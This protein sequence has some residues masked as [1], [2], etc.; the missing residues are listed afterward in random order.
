MTAAPA[1]SGAAGTG[2]SRRAAPVLTVLLIAAALGGWLG[3]RALAAQHHLQQARTQLTTAKAALLDRRTDDARAAIAAATRDTGRARALTGDPLWR[4]AAAVPVA[5][6]SL[7]AVRGV[8]RAFDEVA[9]TVLPP[10][11]GAAQALSGGELR[12]PGGT[13]DLE[14]L[15][16]AEPQLANSADRLSR[17]RTRLAGLPTAGVVAPVRE[18]RTQLTG[19]LDSLADVLGRS[20]Q[21][22]TLAPQLLG[23]GRPRRF[24]V[25]VQQPGE[26]RGTGGLPGGYAVLEADNGTVRVSAQGSN[27]D[28]HNGDI[29]LPEGVSGDFEQEYGANLALR[30]WQNV[31]LS[32]DLPTVAKVVAARWKAQSGQDVDGVITLDPV[33]IS[34]LLR[35]QGPVDMSDG[36]RVAPADLVRYLTV[37]QYRG[38]TDLM[39]R[40]D[41]LAEAAKAATERVTSGAAD[42]SA[43]LG[44]LAEAVRSGHLRMAGVEP[45][46]ERDLHAAG[47]DGA[48][49]TGEAPVAYPVVLNATQG[50]LDSFLDRSVAY[51]AGPCSGD[52][53]ASTITVRLRNDAPATGLPPYLT[54]RNDSG[55]DVQST[56]SA[57]LLQTYGSADARLVRAELDG[58]AVTADSGPGSSRLYEGLEG[59]LPFWQ[60]Y[61]ELP[62]GQT[63]TVVLHLQEAVVPGA[64]RVPE[65]PLIRPMAR[66]VD[67][68]DCS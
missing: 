23:A 8:T 68:P 54:I 14:V 33:S 30:Y 43:L 1:A 9:R 25:L 17:A 6:D 66:T 5:G 59:D 4:L 34:D 29:P 40:K 16:T 21:V 24:F 52:R 64:A 20:R 41:A 11:L 37:E 58:E 63:R 12:H 18:A 55:A 39:Q 28:L 35:G 10:G 44:G 62:R 32:P 2:Q 15:A 49:P 65:Q 51:T 13:V 48:L 38:V 31:N 7:R 67:V 19:Q 46:L 60:T 3:V 22:L 42:T 36:R 57:V 27:A 50:K 26:S 45:G 47:V 56:D 53:R 61:V